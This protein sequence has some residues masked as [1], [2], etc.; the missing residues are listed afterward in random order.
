LAAALFSPLRAA[1]FR[2]L[3]TVGAYL[4]IYLAVIGLSFNQQDHFYGTS[5]FDAASY[6]SH[7]FTI[8]LDGDL[9]YRNELAF[10]YRTNLNRDQTAP[11]QSMGMGL[12]AAPFIA[13]FSVIDRANHHPILTDRTA[14]IGSWSYFGI[15]FATA[16]YFLA[17]IALYQL[18]L[19][20]WVN[21]FIVA[22][23]VIS[24]GLLPYV[25]GIFAFVHAY[26]FFTL[27]ALTAACIGLCRAREAWQNGVLVSAIGATTFLAFM[28]RWADYGILAVPLLAVLTH[29]LIEHDGPYRRAIALSYTGVLGG[30]AA[31]SLFHLWAFGIAWPWAEYFYRIPNKFSSD[32]G[33]MTELLR[34]VPNLPLL[35]FSSEFGVLWTFPLLPIGFAVGLFALWRWFWEEP[36]P[37]A[38]WALAI[39]WC[40]AVPLA[41]VLLWKT[42]ASGY[43]YRY[44]LPSLPA[45]MLILA[46]FFKG[47]AVDRHYNHDGEWA[48]TIGVLVPAAFLA[49]VSFVAQIGFC[50]LP[51]FTPKPQLNVFGVEHLAS[52]RGYMDAVFGAIARP[53]QWLELYQQSL[54]VRIM[55]PSVELRD[56]PQLVDQ[57]RIL[58]LVIPLI[59]AILSTAAIARNW[60]RF[61]I[62]AA[63]IL[64]A[65]ALLWPF[66]LRSIGAHERPLELVAFG[67]RSAEPF[68]GNGFR[69]EAPGYRVSWIFERPAT[70]HGMLPQSPGVKIS[71]HFYN[72]HPNQTVTV[73][74]NGREIGEWNANVGDFQSSLT[75]RLQ[76]SEAGQVG[77]IQFMVNRIEPFEG[78]ANAALGVMMYSVTVKAE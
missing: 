50:K 72:P 49:L 39:G 61:A 41:I 35:L 63:W 52:A 23:A 26:E 6:V 66:A 32:S 48:G 56:M 74:L 71:A 54:F 77:T 70:I 43:G 67:T 42:T 38:L 9:D 62:S 4:L 69:K 78:S 33:V 58:L 44:L 1:D 21:S 75:T 11:Q 55:T 28:V 8:G 20:R 19:G 73:L 57:F 31:V 16:F 25:T 13:A 15:Q 7:A 59:G 64:L 68:V 14:F 76:A 17:G 65:A 5:K 29:Y 18:A 47:E 22:T 51:G 37:W 40:I 34:N 53:S 12:L 10:F 30:L 27:A 45:L 24:A 46:V 36:L 2:A 60:R 3:A